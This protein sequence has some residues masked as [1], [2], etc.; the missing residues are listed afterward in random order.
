MTT[1]RTDTPGQV[2]SKRIPASRRFR[3]GIRGARPALPL[4]AAPGAAGGVASC[5]GAGI[6][7]R[8]M[9][10]PLETADTRRGSSASGLHGVSARG[11]AKVF[12]TRA[13]PGGALERLA[14]EAD[15]QVWPG[16][17][18]PDP[19]A[20]RRA[21]REAKGLVCLLSDDIDAALL[22]ACPHLQAVSSCS[23]GVD[24]VDLVAATAR[25]IPVGH[26]P[27]VLTET[28]AELAFALLLAA[29]RRVAEGDRFV[30][31]GR[32]RAE[33]GWDPE[34]L[35]GRDLLGETLGIVGLG[36]TGRAMARR[37]LGFGMHV[38]GWSRSAREVPGVERVALAEL[39]RRSPFVSVHLALTPETRG[40]LGHE[41]LALLP[42]GAV[43]VNTARGGIVDEDALAE[44]LGR[45]HLHA[46]GLDVYAREPLPESSPLRALSNVVLLPHIGSASL[47]TR[48]RMA[49][50][51]VRNLRAALAGQPMPYCA[52][53]EV[54]G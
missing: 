47:A 35:L 34:L 28:T 6:L 11:R 3:T 40:L 5:V 39:L 30:R 4:A 44:A 29:A 19:Q 20:L 27:G 45:G 17:A 21:C 37:A 31:A 33:A 15:L 51:A 2:I 43:L 50:R 23:V 36:A 24:H 25:G 9:S 22:E 13:L 26:T 1:D 52:N 14:A 38:L 49:E 8:S 18:P 41:A 46:A 10:P 16:P 12:A 42:R 48:A 54:Y 53:P 32:W 7:P